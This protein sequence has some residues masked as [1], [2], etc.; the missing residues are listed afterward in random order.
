MNAL[1]DGF[2]ALHK[3][4]GPVLLYNIWDAGSA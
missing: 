1:R 2:A 4:G 3:P